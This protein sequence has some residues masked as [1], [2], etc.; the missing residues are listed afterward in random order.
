VV[1]PEKARPGAASL[2]V[3]AMV[4]RYKLL[5]PL[6]AGGMAHVWAAKPEGTLGF[7]RTVALKVVRPEY[8]ADA[9]YAR[10]LVD[11]ATVAG[12]IH[13][14][15]VCELYEFDEAD[16]L[17]FMVMEWVAGDALS[18]LLHQG[19][20]LKPIRYQYAARIVADACSGVH[21]AHEAVD[22]DGN[23]LNIVHRDI[24]PPN[25][26]L[27]QEGQVKVSDFGIAKARYQL[28]E[29]TRTGDIKGKF[30]YIP[31]E[32]IV[33]RGISR[34]SDV[35]ALG[36]VLYV[37]TLGLRPFGRGPAAMPKILRGQYRRPRDLLEPYPEALEAIIVKAL[38]PDPADRFETAEQM[39]LTLEQWI[40]SSGNVVTPSDIARVVRRRLSPER[41]QTIDALRH[42]HKPLL[43]ALAEQGARQLTKDERTQT[44]TASSGLVMRPD[45]LSHSSAGGP[46][47]R[48]TLEA[49]AGSDD[50]TVVDQTGP[51]EDD[52]PVRRSVGPISD[53]GSRVSLTAVSAPLPD[54][55]EAEPYADPRDDA[56]AGPRAL[57]IPTLAAD[58]SGQLTPADARPTDRPGRKSADPTPDAPR[59][60]LD[61]SSATGPRRQLFR[62]L[63]AVLLA[64][65]VV[66][67]LTL[68]RQL[69]P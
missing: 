23:P 48:P 69:S 36:C 67:L 28:H 17:F 54:A 59:T 34:R 62:V 35:Y 53:D 7:A 39:R 33:G 9:E 4:G 38:S 20:K 24:S 1:S 46:L 40:T 47:S 41:R 61:S 13:H 60:S 8:A 26:L 31:P 19:D 2:R 11:E 30:A 6:A 58:G 66:T 21:A 42:T 52:S 18:G 57:S 16:G 10:M 32:Q 43:L 63:I 27:S 45:E 51:K 65:F 44:P 5:A 49:A 64:A 22:P 29:R 14:P 56:G 55:E 68:T 12:A 25:I 50:S 15:N 37:A 3:G